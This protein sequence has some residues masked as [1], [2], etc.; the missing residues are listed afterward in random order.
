MGSPK[1]TNFAIQAKYLAFLQDLTD[2]QNKI[3]GLKYQLVALGVPERAMQRVDFEAAKKAYSTSIP[4]YTT[5]VNILERLRGFI[6][7]GADPKHIDFDKLF[8]NLEEVKL[9]L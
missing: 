8:S 7:M 6:L 5:K 2:R 1:V 9:K 4:Y 3:D